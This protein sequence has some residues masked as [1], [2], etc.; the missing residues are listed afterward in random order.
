MVYGTQV[1]WFSTI[2]Y[3]TVASVLAWFGMAIP[4]AVCQGTTAWQGFRR[5]VRLSNGFEAYLFCLF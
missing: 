5:N 4:L 2:G 3:V 1:F